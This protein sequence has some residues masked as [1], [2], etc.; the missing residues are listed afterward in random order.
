MQI[1]ILKIIFCTLILVEILASDAALELDISDNLVELDSSLN[2][3]EQSA[4]E[5]KESI[6][7]NEKTI[8]EK[9]IIKPNYIQ[10]IPIPKVVK[11]PLRELDSSLNTKEQREEGIKVSIQV[12]ENPGNE[13]TINEQNDL[14][15]I[16]IS[17]VVE[18]P[19]TLNTVGN[20][21][22]RGCSNFHFEIN[23]ETII[24]HI[25]GAETPSIRNFYQPF[26]LCDVPNPFSQENGET[27]CFAV[28]LAVGFSICFIIILHYV[29]L[30]Y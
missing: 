25:V 3:K 2:S 9:T 22:E 28:R 21:E 26:I 24:D 15:S 20:H 10:S 7:V 8:K 27:W 16:P 18:P 12:K 30:K 23:S 29:I 13:E 14:Q 19:Q 11:P 1:N 4:E 17:E 5:I 6:H